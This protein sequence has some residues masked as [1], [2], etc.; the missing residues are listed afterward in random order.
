M[1]EPLVTV[2]HIRLPPEGGG[3]IRALSRIGYEL[4][5]ALADLIDNCIDAEAKRVEITFLRNDREITAVTIADDGHGMDMAALRLG[6]QFAGNT[7]HNSSDLGTYG[8]GLKSASLSQSKTMTVISRQNGTVVAGRWS[9]EAI[10]SDWQCELL[11][12]AGASAVFNDLCLRGKAPVC[13]TLVIWERLD[14]LAVGHQA[15]ALEEFLSTALPRLEAHLGLTFHRF[16]E[17][18]ALSISIVVR[19]ERRALALPRAV[20][21]HDPFRYANSGSSGWPTTLQCDMP[22]LGPLSLEAHIWP[23]GSAADGFLLG[24]RKGIEFQGFYFY[25]NNRLIQSGGWNGVIKSGQETDL[26]LARILV[27]LPPNGIDVNVQKSALQ[28]TAAQA[29]AFLTASDGAIDFLDYLEAARAAYRAHRR[30]DS[31]PVSA[32]VVPGSG[33]PMPV[34]RSAQKRIAGLKPVEEVG[35]SWENL[36]DEQVFDLDLTEMKI[37]LNRTYRHEILDGSAA[38]AADAPFVKMLLFQLYKGDFGRSRSS[39]KQRDHIDL[40]NALLFDIIRVRLRGRDD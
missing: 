35:F 30:S 38:S 23:G 15:D 16:L 2:D 6:M 17:S 9:F 40:T 33:M 10:G 24:S 20:R 28:V 1:L 12:P 36:D 34:R 5:A 26:M 3:T 32:P 39:R 13:G 8:M 25:R 14:R 4:P 31:A 27:D 7:A 11:D 18:G 19:H 22:G 29:Q 37:V 21:P